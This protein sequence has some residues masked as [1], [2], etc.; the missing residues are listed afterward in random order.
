M[1]T[2]GNSS[3]APAAFEAPELSH[4]E[5][6]IVFGTLMLAMLLAAL[7][8][9]V[10][11]T[12]LPTIVGELGGLEHLAW[13][14]T[15]YMLAST[16]SVPLYG[17]LGDMYGRKIMLQVAIA[18]FIIGSIAAGVSQDMTQ[19]IGSRVIQG[20]G[21]G[22]LMATSQA[23]IGD[24]LSPRE[25]GKYIGYLASVFAFA[26][27]AGP[28]IGGFFTDG[29]GWRWVFYINVPLGLLALFVTTKVLKLHRHRVKHHIDFIGS[30]LL[31]AG[32]SSVLLATT[33]GG[34]QY[35]WGSVEIVGLFVGGALLLTTFIFFE[36]RAEEPIIPLSLFKDQTFRI[37]SALG[38]LL[39]MA[40]FGAIAFVPVYL[41]VVKGV[42]ATE[43]GLRTVPMMV[44]IV[45]T[46]IVAG[47]MIT[48][49]GQYRRY[50]VFGTAMASLG[51][52][53]LS[54]LSADSSVWFLS[55]DLFILGIGI[56][57]VMQITLLAVQNSVNFRDMGAATSGVT[58]F[59]SMGGAFG[60]AMFGSILSNRL[61]YHLPRFVD[62]N[63][64]QG[65]GVRELTGS[66]ERLRALPPEV[67]S[68]VHQ[69]FSHSLETVFLL[70]VPLA[71]V[72][73]AL[74]WLLPHVPLRERVAPGTRPAEGTEEP[75][76][77]IVIEV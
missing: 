6:L 43:S 25:R 49:T 28:L 66:P 24:I 9:T 69:A 54:R 3:A 65:I 11:A 60:V 29:I 44:G 14:I 51:L 42:S 62:L 53:L 41:Q 56:G 75:A 50:P 47:R 59:R 16:S 23:I 21:A 61:S 33:W 57:L 12:A 32:V 58:F 35:A 8:Q 70:S 13:V 10:L 19:I 7:D 48:K 73:F 77:P 45:L 2:N 1:A 74:S 36:Q 22:G 5:I 76:P 46:S 30:A 37:S 68:G 72:A 31:V 27:V 15:A 34:N 20:L 38:L 63:E 67:L 4:R 52:F 40:M 26:S 17:K 18:M 39:G 64:L 55:V 71:L